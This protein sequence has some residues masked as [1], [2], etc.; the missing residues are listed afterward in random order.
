MAESGTVGAGVQGGAEAQD[1][2]GG[3]EAGGQLA[4]NLV[5]FLR[6]LRGLGV[7]ASTAEAMDAFRG[8]A[9]LGLG[10]RERVRAALRATL[11][12]GSDEGFVLDRAFELFVAPPAERHRAVEEH[13]RRQEQR[14]ALEQAGVREA[15]RDLRFQGRPLELSLEQKLAYASMGEDERR[16]LRDFL[17]R[18]S[19]G[20]RVDATLTPLVVN[21]VRGHLDRW[22]RQE[23]EGR[24]AL[25]PV[26]PTGD[27]EIDAMLLEVAG[28]LGAGDGLPLIHADLGSVAEADQGRLAEVVRRLAR[29]LATRISRRYRQ[30]RSP[31]LIDLRRTIRGNLRFGG[32]PFRLRYRARR[33]RR[34]RL[35]LVCDVSGSMARYSRFV[36]QFTYGLYRAVSGIEAFL[37]SEDLERVTPWFQPRRPF[38]ATVEEVLSRSRQWSRGTNL[39]TALATLLR[40]HRHVLT[41]ATIVI[42]VSDTRT[43]ALAGAVAG[44]ARVRRLVRE[45]VWLNTVPKGQWGSMASVA[46]LGRHCQMHECYTLAHLNRVLR[47]QLLPG[48][49]AGLR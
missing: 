13:R 39:S 17:H 25:L 22:R 40:L 29:R 19:T 10:E 28:R 31:R 20:H 7:R 38:E 45:V 30:S 8:L 16:R 44:L 35:V 32:A 42:V 34:P 3:G 23:E 47:S 11:A 2:G 18:T 49:G 43:L 12:K 4:A 33:P 14:A 9:L 48:R 26:Q 6:L 41:P 37:F 15:E 27:E 46:A 24:P 1:K 21:I 5:L 36:L